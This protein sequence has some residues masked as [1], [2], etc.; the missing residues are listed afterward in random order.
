MRMRTDIRVWFLVVL[1]AATVA[2]ATPPASAAPRWAPASKATIHPGVRTFTSGTQ[3]RAGFIFYDAHAVYL[4]QAA[5]CSDA[6]PLGTPVKIEGASR[7]GRLVYNSWLVSDIDGNDF[8]LVRIDN[9]DR[10]RVNPSVPF[11]GGP[12]ADGGRSSFGARVYTY[13]NSEVYCLEGDCRR[14]SPAGVNTLSPRFGIDIGPAC[15]LG[16]PAREGWTHSI[17]TVAPGVSG[18]Q[19]SAV[20]DERGRALGILGYPWHDTTDMVTDL[21]KAMAYMKANTNLDAIQLAKGTEPF[22]PP[23]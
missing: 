1:A 9:V 5:W 16:C 20:L 19:G 13:G 18:D 11:W 21:P 15:V 6:L 8:A 14:A 10:G 4:S 3:C 22:L 7:P 17:Y 2:T 23:R 12:V